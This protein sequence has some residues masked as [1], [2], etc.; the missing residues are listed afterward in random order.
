MCLSRDTVPSHRRRVVMVQA[1]LMNHRGAVAVDRQELAL[2]EA[3]PGTPSW[4]PIKH[5]VVLDRVCETLDGAGFGIESM[6]LSVA[7]NE[8][9]FFG[10]LNLYNKVT[11]A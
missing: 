7:R 1:T 6:Q 10:V 5:T 9:R 2:I 3:P 11:D 8:Q 4:F